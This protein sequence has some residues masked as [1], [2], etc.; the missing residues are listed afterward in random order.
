MARTRGRW[1]WCEAIIER[2]TQPFEH[3][4]LELG[5]FIEEEDTVVGERP[6]A[7]RGH[8]AP[9]DQPHI[10]N[11]MVG[12]A[13]RPGGD[14]GGAPPGEAG[15]AMDAGGVDGLGQGHL[16]EDVVRRRGSIDFPAPGG[17]RSKTSGAECWH[18]CP[19]YPQGGCLW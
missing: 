19:L 13:T 1:Y 17:P 15:D 16:G 4:P 12:G 14:D 3:M 2:L 10:G 8:L 11:G 9:T 6:L 18:E 7:R 5:E